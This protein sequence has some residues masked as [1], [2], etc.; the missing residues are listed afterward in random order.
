M[1]THIEKS[2]TG[3]VTRNKFWLTGIVLLVVAL[4]SPAYAA[5]EFRSN[6]LTISLDI[7]TG[8]I[9]AIMQKQQTGEFLVGSGQIIK[10]FG[11][12]SLHSSDFLAKVDG[13]GTG[14]G[15]VDGAGTGAAKVDGAGTG[16]AK[17]DGAGTGAGKV[18]GAGTGA[19]KAASN[20]TLEILSSGKDEFIVVLRQEL[21]GEMISETVFDTRNGNLEFLEELQVSDL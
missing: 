16:A 14:A 17:V 9:A 8:H 5:Q 12:F 19:A 21:K 15:K 4:V 11:T 10:G 6:G 2:G 7:E 18:D 3:A 1:S 13:A 20:V